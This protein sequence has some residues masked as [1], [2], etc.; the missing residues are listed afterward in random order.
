MPL[1]L[2]HRS[3]LDYWRSHPVDGQRI[4]YSRGK[5]VF[6]PKRDCDPC[7]VLQDLVGLTPDLFRFP[8]HV[9]V[10]D[11]SLRIRSKHVVSHI[12]QGP[13]PSNS[14]AVA[15]KSKEVYVASI[16]L[17][18]VQMGES[19]DFRKLICLGDEFCGSY[20]IRNSSSQG[21][22]N[23]A[24][25]SSAS[26]IG[27][28]LA[29]VRGVHGISVA[30]RALR[31]V[32][33]GSASPME[34]IVVVLLCLPCSLGGYGIPWP[35]LNYRIAPSWAMAQMVEKSSY[36]CDLCWPEARFSIEYDSD[37]WH[38]GS[39]RIDRDS[40]RRNAL[41]SL[42]FEVMTLT[43]GQV[44]EYRAFD[45]FARQVAKCLGYRL[46]ENVADCDAR[47]LELRSLLFGLINDPL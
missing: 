46:R 17:C 27:T 37:F 33:D 11:K 3:A 26:K 38:T 35:N 21:F 40:R 16:E 9:L 39:L 36:V 20:S 1:Y 30:R 23:R 4:S 18:F 42:G 7:E 32:I 22:V 24:A 8:I 34:T 28:Y 31:Y 47:R 5:A 44:F 10:P 19:S 14:F 15:S 41:L 2:S 25:L 13:V 6:A 29:A 45:R 43:K 12:W